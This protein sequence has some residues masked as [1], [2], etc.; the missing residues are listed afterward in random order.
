MGYNITKPHLKHTSSRNLL[1]CNGEYTCTKNKQNMHLIKLKAVIFFNP[2][3]K[4]DM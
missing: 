3:M 2:F 4:F 1:L